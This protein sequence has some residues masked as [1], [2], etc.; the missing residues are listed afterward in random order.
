M[1]S[2]P[3]LS[4]PKAVTLAHMWSRLCGLVYSFPGWVTWFEAGVGVSGRAVRVEGG[5]TCSQTTVESSSWATSLS[6]VTWGFIHSL[7]C[8]CLSSTWTGIN[9]ESVNIAVN[10][11]IIHPKTTTAEKR[12]YQVSKKHFSLREESNFK[13]ERL[14]GIQISMGR[15]ENMVQEGKECGQ[16]IWW[17]GLASPSQKAT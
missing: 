1:L 6:V 9:H 2:P 16:N 4:V 12:L 11:L 15:P 8:G 17:Q 10:I 7:L 5:V 13:K 14:L 3:L